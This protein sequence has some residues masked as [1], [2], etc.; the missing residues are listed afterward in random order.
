[1]LLPFWFFSPGQGRSALPCR[2]PAGLAH[3]N[4]HPR[5]GRGAE[6][7]RRRRPAPRSALPRRWTVPVSAVHH[8]GLEPVTF[9]SVVRRPP[10]L[11]PPVATA[12]RSLTHCEVGTCAWP[13]FRGF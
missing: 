10:V 6:P 13:R 4:L 5:M 7:G 2:P 1:M 8:T 9:G 12:L 11:H 3:V